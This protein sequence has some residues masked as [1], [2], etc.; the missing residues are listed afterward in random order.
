MDQ[1]EK[2]RMM[3]QNK[4][5]NNVKPASFSS[6][7][8]TVTSGKGGVGKTNTTVNLA[9][10]LTKLGKKVVILDA[11]LGLANI[12]LLLGIT[13]KYTLADVINGKK[14]IE[15]ILTLGPLGIKFISGGS[16]IQQLISVSDSQ[17]NFFVQN[18]VKLDKIADIILIDTGAGLSNSVMSFVKAVNEI[19]IVTTPEPTSI[20]DAY[21]LIKVLKSD[22]SEIPK[23]NIIINRV[24][25]DNE[26]NEVFEKLCKVSTK[27]LQINL[28]NLGYIQ[29]DPYLVKAV[30]RQQPV[31][32][33]YPKAISTKAF[34]NIGSKLLNLHSEELN[35]SGI[36]LFI[37]RLINT[38]N[39]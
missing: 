29:Y 24:D 8:I 18:L 33:L 37:K 36:T 19:I 22:G 39:I 32:I 27:F 21:S 3:F 4:I 13:P 16:G 6:R 11:D 7:I 35:V 30:K 34:E 25:D 17:L 15:E 20:T 12:E 28:E 2:L 5:Q 38:F 1:A 10:Q 23:I 31:M 26:G 9:I 14:T